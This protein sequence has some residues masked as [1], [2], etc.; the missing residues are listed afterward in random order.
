VLAAPP[1]AE[2]APVAAEPSLGTE[3]PDAKLAPAELLAAA[4]ICTELGR[5]EE[6]GQVLPLLRDAAK[7]LG[8]RGMIVWVWDQLAEELRPALVHGYSSKVRARLRAMSSTA[9]NV[10]AA[11]YRAGATLAVGG[12]ERSTGAL[13]VPLLA[14]SRCIGVLAIELPDAL[15]QDPTIRAVATFM[16]AMLAQLVGGGPAE[17]AA[18]AP[19]LSA[20]EAHPS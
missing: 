8:A 9:D 14:P 10:T 13:A 18:D 1:A 7:V 6:T 4:K 15:E 19:A 17:A 3:A 16:A 5:V 12:G 20:L 11:A 2:A